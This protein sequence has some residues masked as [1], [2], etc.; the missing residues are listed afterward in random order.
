MLG[1]GP[2]RLHEVIATCIGQRETPGMTET[3]HA[4][5]LVSRVGVAAEGKCPGQ[6]DR[7]GTTGTTP[8]PVPLQGGGESGL[9]AETARA[10]EGFAVGGEG[11]ASYLKAVVRG[12]VLDE[13]ACD[14]TAPPSH[15]RVR[16]LEVG[17]GNNDE[18]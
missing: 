4:S 18:G 8:R 6:V 1:G 3:A 13:F 9:W 12:G 16:E 10:G 7:L 14:A 5:C 17:V 15:D 11:P 2:A